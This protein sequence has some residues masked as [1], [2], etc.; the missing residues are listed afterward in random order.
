LHPLKVRMTKNTGNV[1]NVLQYT[2]PDTNNTAVVIPAGAL[3]IAGGTAG[4]LIVSQD[5]SLGTGPVFLSNGV[6]KATSA[7]NIDNPVAMT[8][9]P[10]PVVLT[11]S[12]LTFSGQSFLTGGIT[13]SV[14]NTTTFNS[15][16]AGSA[17]LTLT[18][19]PV[20]VASAN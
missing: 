12:D 2:G 7:V 1:A 9:G 14:N 16:M 18:S 8:G 19:Q 11:G 5:N 17:P 13:L 10:L 20:V 6:L 15:D 4:T 3:S